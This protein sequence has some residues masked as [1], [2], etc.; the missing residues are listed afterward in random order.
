MIAWPVQ[1]FVFHFPKVAAPNL[2]NRRALRQSELMSYERLKRGEFDEL[3]NLM[4]IG[5]LLIGLRIAG[6]LNRAI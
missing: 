5:Q 1:F 6:T 4:G 3:T 2:D